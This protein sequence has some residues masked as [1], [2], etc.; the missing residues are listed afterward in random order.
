MRVVTRIVEGPVIAEN[1]AQARA[2][3]DLAGAPDETGARVSFEG[4]VR[5]REN[6]PHQDRVRTLEALDY[7]VYESMAE[8]GLATLAHSIGT[9]H[10]LQAIV[11]LHSRGRV[12]VGEVSFVLEVHAAHRAPA[13]AAMTEFIDAL[14]RDVPIWKRPVWAGA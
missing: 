1:L 4:V 7:E 6:D 3:R 11:A 13:I 14:K 2:D 5:R 9:R 10:G 8:Q 12:R